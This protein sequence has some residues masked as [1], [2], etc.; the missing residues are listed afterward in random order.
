MTLGTISHMHDIDLGQFCLVSHPAGMVWTLN[1]EFF[2]TFKGDVNCTYCLS[3]PFRDGTHNECR[4]HN[5]RHCP[6][7]FNN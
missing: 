7:E 4:Q 3:S 1:G 6:C 2:R 5:A